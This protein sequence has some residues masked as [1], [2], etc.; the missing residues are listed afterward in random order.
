MYPS[1]SFGSQAPDPDADC[2]LFNVA[3]SGPVYVLPGSE[4]LIEL[5]V[6]FETTTGEQPPH[7]VGVETVP[8]VEPVPV[9]VEPVP[10]GV[11]PVPDGVEPVPD[12]VEPVPVGVE[13]V[14]V[15]VE[16]VPVG[17]DVVP[18]GVGV[19]VSGMQ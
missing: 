18:V 13:P 19:V 5:E 10:V 12:G 7:G 1:S 8:D 9:G 17:V 2:W 3:S 16:P 6:I 15:V 11:E 4:T 14:P